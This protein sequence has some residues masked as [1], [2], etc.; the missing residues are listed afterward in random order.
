[1]GKQN[2]VGQTDTGSTP[3]EPIQAG[4][5]VETMNAGPYTYVCLEKDGKRGWAAVPVTEVKV[6]DEVELRGGTPMGAF[7]SKSLKRTFDNIV[8]AAGLV[9]K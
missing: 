6:G 9:K 1:L 3:T 8:F 4:K 2:Q 7:T 5:V